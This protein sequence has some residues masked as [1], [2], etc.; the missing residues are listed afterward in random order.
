M[1]YINQRDGGNRKVIAG[2]FLLSANLRGLP[3]KTI[4][5]IYVDHIK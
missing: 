1:C 3:A 2:Q 4:P 5:L